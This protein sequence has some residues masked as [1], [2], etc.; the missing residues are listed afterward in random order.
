VLFSRPSI[1]VLFESAA[2]TY[3]EGLVGLVLTGA[4]ED[5]ARGAAS[6][7][8]AGGTILVQNPADAFAPAMPGAAH[9]ACPAAQV[10]SLDAI[11]D[12]LLGLANL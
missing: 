2:D 5:G 3:G 11:T 1:D 8:A 9:A 6:V 12:Y 10:L 4:N 7:C